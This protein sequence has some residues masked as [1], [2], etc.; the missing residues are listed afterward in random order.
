MNT[1]PPPAVNI[2]PPDC[3]MASNKKLQYKFYCWQLSTMAEWIHITDTSITFPDAM[4]V[5]YQLKIFAKRPLDT[6]TGTLHA[7]PQFHQQ[8]VRY[9]TVFSHILCNSY[10]SYHFT[11][12]RLTQLWNKHIIVPS[13]VLNM[14]SI[15]LMILH[16]LPKPTLPCWNPWICSRFLATSNG[17]TKVLAQT[18][19]KEPH[20]RE[21][22]PDKYTYSSSPL[23]CCTVA[24]N[25]D[26]YNAKCL[27]LLKNWTAVRK[28]APKCHSVRQEP[29]SYESSELP[30][31]P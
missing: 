29:C 11:L 10:S 28:N 30:T 25:R 26:W 2:P 27:E 14:M 22:D 3:H 19:A 6:L 7:L 23:F 4:L 9:M 31:H 21:P 24:N 5:W 15:L 8:N 16:T 12:C 17:Y 13:S 18:P 20:R 1:L